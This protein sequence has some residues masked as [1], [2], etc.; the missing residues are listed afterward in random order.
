MGNF[1][2]ALFL[3]LAC[4]VPAHA[5]TPAKSPDQIAAEI[6]KVHPK[7]LILVFDVSASTKNGGIF[8]QERAASATLLR[9]GCVSGDRVILETFGT[10]YKQ[11][12]DMTLQ[13]S[14]DASALIDKLPQDIEPGHGTNI[15]WPHH[16]ALKVINDGLPKPGVIVLLTDSFN[17][18]PLTTDKTYTD[19]LNYYTLKGLTVYPESAQN[20]DYERLLAKLKDS[21]KLTQYGVGVGIADTGRPIERLP[22]GPGQGDPDTATTNLQPTVINPVGREKSGSSLPLIIGGL[23]AA[24]ALG[25]LAVYSFLNRPVPVRL[26]LGDKGT[27]R[28][29]RLKPNAKIG[30]GG[31]LTSAAPGDDSF[32]LAGLPVPAA[33]IQAKSGSATLKLGPAFD[34]LP[35]LK[36]FHNGA[37]L[38]NPAPLRIGDEIRLLLPVTDSSPPRE[39]RVHFADPK[40]AII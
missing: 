9:Q 13:S 14:G 10:A 35:G 37:A 39:H 27:P 19:Y 3:F 26:T 23:V 15:R 6:V 30:L 16:E 5:Q 20:R 17:D 8:G 11:V 18:R 28:D 22:V 2:I 34:S 36:V 21:G 40:G 31:T 38:E 33:F 25:G 7:T 1:K 4:L 32:P 24:L 29:Y 12:F